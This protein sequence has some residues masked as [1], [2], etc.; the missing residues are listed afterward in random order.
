MIITISNTCGF[1]KAVDWPNGKNQLIEQRGEH[2]CVL[3][4]N[5]TVGYRNT[6]NR[7]RKS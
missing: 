6:L 1:A 3:A 7:R 4:S 2:V 5:A